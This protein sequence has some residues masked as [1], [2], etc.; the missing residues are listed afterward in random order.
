MY[1]GYI[2]LFRKTID[3]VVFTNPE[4]L[5]VWIW[6]L[7]NAN[8]KEKWFSINTGRGFTE[9]QCKAGEFITGRNEA[10]RQLQLSP[11]KIRNLLSKLQKFQNIEL[12]SSNFYTK[13]KVLNYI[14][15]Q[16]V[17]EDVDQATA[18]QQPNNRQ[19][20]AIN[21]PTN[22]HQSTTT[23]NDKN[24]NNEKNDKNY[25]GSRL[26]KNDPLYDFINFEKTFL[27]SKYENA[28]LEFY[29]ESVKNWADSNGTKKKDWGATARNFML[30]DLKDNKLRLKNGTRTI[31][32]EER[33]LQQWAEANLND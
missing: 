17:T 33:E 10:S 16:Q 5:K 18:K 24:V 26:F 30:R 11:S 32:D 14:D 9:V 22:S 1:R 7:F 8:H 20:I 19:R 25:K 15:Y 31:T 3:S 4:L 28:D 21:Q 23:N 29:Y 12:E 2:K 13:I 6:C 27:N